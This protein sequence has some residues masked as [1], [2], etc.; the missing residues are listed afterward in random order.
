MITV[1]YNIVYLEGDKRPDLNKSLLRCS[2]TD[3]YTQHDLSLTHASCY[4]L[5]S[6]IFFSFFSVST[7]DVIYVCV[8]KVLPS[9]REAMRTSNGMNN[10]LAVQV[11]MKERK[12]DLNYHHTHSATP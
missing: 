1:K 7:S 10:P 4:T 12:S 6:A 5:S 8:F 11:K 9:I 3:T 2:N